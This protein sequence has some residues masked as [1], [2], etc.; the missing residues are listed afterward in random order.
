M[1]KEHVDLAIQVLQL[2]NKL[3]HEA[4]KTSY[5]NVQLTS[6]QTIALMFAQ[7]NHPQVG[8]FESLLPLEKVQAR[9]TTIFRAYNGKH[10]LTE[11]TSDDW[12]F[13]TYRREKQWYDFIVK[14]ELL[15]HTLRILLKPNTTQGCSIVIGCAFDE[16]NE[17]SIAQRIGW[18]AVKKIRDLAA[19][20]E[21]ATAVRP[22]DP[23]QYHLPPPPK[24]S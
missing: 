12:I 15:T 1:K 22:L 6:D 24:K 11:T 14:Q 4:S 10:L 7:I 9:L 2:G 18:A 17:L 8:A 20:L 19:V 21:P 3:F 13:T 23:Q 5:A 16:I